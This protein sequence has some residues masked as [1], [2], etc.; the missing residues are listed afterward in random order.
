V[1]HLLLPG[2]GNELLSI[3]PALFSLLAGTLV[4]LD[5][6]DNYLS[7]LPDSLQYCTSLEELSISNNPIRVLPP[8]MGELVALRM[9]VLDGCMLQSLPSDLSSLSRLHTLCGGCFDR[10]EESS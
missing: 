6:S 7:F 2:L 9:L 5:V 4:V 3:L 8:W 1:T 10:R